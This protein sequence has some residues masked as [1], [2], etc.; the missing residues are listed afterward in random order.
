MLLQEAEIDLMAKLNAMQQSGASTV[1]SYA[2]VVASPSNSKSNR[3]TE[4]YKQSPRPELYKQSPRPELHKQF[5]TSGSDTTTSSSH[6]PESSTMSC[7]NSAP[8]LFKTHPCR[9]PPHSFQSTSFKPP[10]FLPTP[11]LKSVQFLHPI[12]ATPP[13]ITSQPPFQPCPQCP[14]LV[15]PPINLL[16]TALLQPQYHHLSHPPPQ[17]HPCLIPPPSIPPLPPPQHSS[18][19]MHHVPPVHPLA[20]FHLAPLPLSTQRSAQSFPLLQPHP[21][22]NH[23]QSTPTVAYNPALLL[24]ILAQLLTPQLHQLL[25]SL[26]Y[27]H[28]QVK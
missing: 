3:T 2:S 21:S 15:P 7:S 28:T 27:H 14:F 26:P 1:K 13:P 22:L 5:A 20:P 19:V 8:F 17:S 6:T 24:Q 4:L 11:L 18:A 12:P 25:L 9:K 23:P 16:S 10:F